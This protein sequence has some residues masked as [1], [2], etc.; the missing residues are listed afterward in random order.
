MSKD[1]KQVR[2]K[3]KAESRTVLLRTK[4]AFLKT[5]NKAA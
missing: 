3:L 1:T 5:Y 2:Y 4:V